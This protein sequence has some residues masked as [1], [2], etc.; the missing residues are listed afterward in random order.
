MINAEE[1][2][3][4]RVKRGP[5]KGERRHSWANAY[6]IEGKIELMV[7]AS[8]SAAVNAVPYWAQWGWP[9]WPDYRLHITMKD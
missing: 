8:R 2:K 7:F 4:Y 5:N 1:L 3:N 6:T 9:D